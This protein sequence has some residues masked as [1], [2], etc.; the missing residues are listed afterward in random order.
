[1][2]AGKDGTSTVESTPASIGA[3]MPSPLTRKAE[4]LHRL[5]CGEEEV[6]QT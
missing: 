1:M 2:L 5:V 3:Q 6:L 4:P